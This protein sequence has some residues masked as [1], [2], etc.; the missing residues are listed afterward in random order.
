MA[1]NLTHRTMKICRNF[2]LLLLLGAIPAGSWAQTLVDPTKP[3]A[4]LGG[5][6]GEAVND[7]RSII[8]S[9]TRRAAII[10]GQTVELGA[11]VG[12]V[13]LIEIS[14]RGVVLQGEKGRQVLTLFPRVNIN[15]KADLPPMQDEVKRPIRK[16]ELLDKLSSLSGSE[17]ER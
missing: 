7:L 11:K 17:E 12:D 14:E 8:I 2:G 6:R 1:K 16:E 4:E 15:K 13:R 5:A 3:P 9:P 10:N